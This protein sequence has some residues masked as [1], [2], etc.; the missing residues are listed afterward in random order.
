MLRCSSVFRYG[1]GVTLALVLAVT[2]GACAS[3][4]T[5][6]AEPF[7]EWEAE[8][9]P[10]RDSLAFRVF[11]VGNTATEPD[12]EA[13]ALD[14]LDAQLAEAGEHSAV[15]FLGDQLRRPLPDSAAAD[16]A[17]VEASLERIVEVVEGY[18][19]RVIV[20]PGDRDWGESAAALEREAD[21]LAARLGEEV[22]VPEDGLPGPTAVELTD[23]VVLIALDTEWW[24]R[25]ADERPTGEVDG[26]D[27]SSEVDVL[28]ALTELIDAYEDQ[29][30]IVAGH[31]PV[32]STGER[33]GHY[34]L[35]QH[36]FPLTDLWRP[37][38]VPLPVVGSAYPL[39]RSYFGGRQDFSGEDYR[40]LREALP[41]V[42]EEHDGV[43]Y[44]AAHE[45]G[46]QYFPFRTDALELQHHV[47][48]GGGAEGGPLAGGYGAGFAHGTEGFA[49]LQFYADDSMWL[50]VWEPGGDGSPGG[51]LAFRT[52]LEE[53][54]AETVD[55][56]LPEIDP[57][58]LP[59]Y[60]DSTRV[61]RADPGLSA[62]PIKRFFLGSSYRD[63]WTAP[64]RVPVLDLGRANGGLTPVKRGG[65]YQTVSLRLEN[66]EGRE[67]VLRQVRKRPD[68]LLP[69]GL[70]GTFAADIFADQIVTSNPYGALVVPRL[71]EAAGIYHTKPEVVVVPDDP[72]LGAYREG[73]AGTLVLFEERPTEEGADLPHFGGGEDIDS[74]PTVFLQL[75]EDNDV[76]V[77]QRFYLRNRLFDLL[78]GDWDRHADQWR[79]A[80]FE[81]FMLDST[82][83]GEARE[84]GRI[85][86]PIPRD[87]D[88]AFFRVTG[89]LPRL[90]QFFV[91]G[92]QDFDPDY[93]DVVGLTDN[94]LELDRRFLN[95]LTR[96]EWQAVAR[97]LR[98]RMTDEV[99]RAALEDWP[100][101][102]DALHGE[103][104][105]RT[106]QSRRDQLLDVAEEFYELQAAVVDVVG[107][108]KHER[109]LVERRDGETE[110]TVYKTS[111]EGEN[112]KVIYRRVFLDD[113]TK[114][115]RLYGLDGRDRFEIGGT[116]DD[117]P[118]VRV[119]GGPGED[120][121]E[122]EGGASDR[123]HVYD[124]ERGNE[125][126]PGRAALTLSD[127][128]AVNRY[129]PDGFAYPSWAVF[130]SVGYNATDGLFLGASVEWVTP[131]FRREPYGHSHL[132]A[133]NVSTFT[134]AVN[135]RYRSRWVEAFGPLDAFVEVEG[136]TPQE[137]RNFYGLGNETTEA[138]GSDFYRVRQARAAA[139]VGLGWSFSQGAELG[140]A[141]AAE[142]TL[143]EQTEGRVFGDLP[144]DDP[145]FD[146]QGFAGGDGFLLLHHEDRDVNPRRGFRW[147]NRAGIRTGV[148][149][150]DDTFGRL[151][152]A[153]A[154]YLS[155]S[156]DPQITLALR[157]GAAH[158]A[159]DF[160]FYEAAT[161]G[162]EST[163]RGYRS[164][165]FSGHSAA[166]QNAELRVG[167]LDFRTYTAAGTLGVLG[168]VDNGR[169]WADGESSTVWHQGYGGG[170]W[171]NLFDLVLLRGTVG[172][173]EEGTFVNIGLGFLY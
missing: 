135:A 91:P 40:E 24:L 93:G 31:H 159:G 46:L 57:A 142:V 80:Q 59:D 137:V 101:E 106:L 166:Y 58:T 111:K 44:A 145:L 149:G 70:H 168:F 35:R 133:A 49:S 11:L 67:F 75:R 152:S 84:Q 36:L 104:V 100:E 162:G 139:A 105:F 87:R 27:V 118:Y 143:V 21:F 68:L 125:I 12:E 39:L 51:T 103:R 109:F 117:G 136:A 79:W 7:E 110:V 23:D 131:K 98:A 4:R 66:P 9:A 56:D 43:V 50:E 140:L 120:A 33:G 123:V 19:G 138:F 148:T 116:T 155:P 83:T 15:V 86:R 5:F 69:S 89:L 81:P 74:T 157:A 54:R 97:D 48:S 134:G 1:R 37:L 124:T 14:A 141:P 113:E 38:Y 92:L 164:T 154:V 128:P 96:D 52:R 65:G 153:L 99:L 32:F 160:P 85:Y 112:R 150:S 158:V 30:V 6:V 173:S 144:S 90:G 88:Q 161:L 78:I 167:L 42:I 114:E 102:I 16:R 26:D 95:E 63:V 2:L 163:L 156:L 47:V 171:A 172:T 132:L 72:R 13:A 8:A 71:A 76:R 62:G 25:E 20:L 121:F 73:F 34:T 94:G 115:L 122:G 28:I 127:D 151:E 10:P 130:P 107:T 146:P 41:P 119:V 170:L 45:R 77:D 3:S 60:T 53:P 17:A 108:D 29:R 55:P 169:V 22:L 61:V 165:R 129:D 18:P 64:V 126:E 82:L 147:E